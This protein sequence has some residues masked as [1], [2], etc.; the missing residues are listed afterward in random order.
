MDYGAW[1]VSEP[2]E[3][4]DAHTKIFPLPKRQMTLAIM[5]STWAYAEGAG[6]R[7]DLLLDFHT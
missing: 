2:R 3:M 4:N 7:R 1:K 6:G 5:S